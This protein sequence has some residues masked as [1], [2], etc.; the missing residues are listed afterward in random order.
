MLVRQGEIFSITIENEGRGYTFAP[1][2]EIIEGDVKHYV[3]S[4]IYWCSKSV[5][6]TRNGGA[7][8]L[9]ETV[10]SI[11][12]IKLYFKCSTNWWF[13]TNVLEKVKL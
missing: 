13:F 3:D 8:H 10:S 5:S 12:Y 6:I 2:I 11:I 7:F 9:D 4:D 1:E